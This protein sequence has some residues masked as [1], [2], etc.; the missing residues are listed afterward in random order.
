MKTWRALIS[1]ELARQNE[2]WDDVYSGTLLDSELDAEFAEGALGEPFTLWTHDRVYF[3][4]LL[5]A[6]QA[7]ASV[8]RLPDGLPTQ[9]IGLSKN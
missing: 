3:P 4:V 2:S 1:D 5:E 7:V 6:G 9:H 8:S